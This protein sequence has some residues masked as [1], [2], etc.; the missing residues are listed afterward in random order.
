MHRPNQRFPIQ[1]PPHIAYGA[2]SVSDMLFLMYH[3]SWILVLL[4]IEIKNSS[5]ETDQP[6]SD[7][8]QLPIFSLQRQ[9]LKNQADFGIS[10]KNIGYFGSRMQ[11]GGGLQDAC[12]SDKSNFARESL[13][14]KSSQ[15][16]SNQSHHIVSI[17]FKNFINK[18][19]NFVFSCT[20]IYC[21]LP[22]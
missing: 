17:A 5:R 19:H 3:N 12:N 2:T 15:V 10:A 11:G 9:G 14:K 21:H 7:I 4:W 13:H 16:R 6:A 22:I 1:S 8:V 18:L 20:Y